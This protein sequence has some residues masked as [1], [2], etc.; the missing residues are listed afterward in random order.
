MKHE[1]KA[2]CYDKKGKVISTA[3]NNY[4]KSHPIQ[5]FFAKQ[6]GN[7]EA[8]FLHAEVAALL[9][10]GVKKPYRIHVERYLK[11]GSPALA[12]PCKSCEKAIKAWKVSEVTYTKPIHHAKD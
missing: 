1:L 12:M 2:T 9:K 8:V 11:D 7:P 4:R 5:A 6:A 10:C 3:A